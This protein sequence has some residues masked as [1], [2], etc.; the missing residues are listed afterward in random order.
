[1]GFTWDDQAD[2]SISTVG[3]MKIRVINRPRRAGDPTP[4]LAS[5]GLPGWGGQRFASLGECKTAAESALGAWVARNTTA[6][7]A[8]AVSYTV[9]GAPS[10][11]VAVLGNLEATI[12]WDPPSNLGGYAASDIT[13]LIESVG[14]AASLQYI[15][16]GPLQA[17]VTGLQNGLSYA[18]VVYAINPVGRSL[19]SAPS[20]YVTPSSVPAAAPGA[21]SIP[22]P[23]GGRNNPI[24][25][26]DGQAVVSWTLA[27]LGSPA[28]ITGFEIAAT[29]AAPSGTHTWANN[30][31]YEVFTDLTPGTPYTFKVRAQ[32]ATGWG[33][34][35]ASSASVTPSGTPVTGP[36]ESDEFDGGTL[37]ARWTEVDPL[38]DGTVTVSGGVLNLA[39]PTGGSKNHDNWPDTTPVNRTL[40]IVQNCGT[41]DWIAETKILNADANDA[42]FGGFLLQADA[43]N[44]VRFDWDG[45][46]GTSIHLYVAVWDNTGAFKQ[47][48]DTA[49]S[50]N[51]AQWMR[52]TKVGTQYTV[53]TSTDGSTFT[54][55]ASFAWTPT[56]TLI[57]LN[58]GSS[59]TATAYTAQF[60][61]FRLVSGGT[62][63][64]P[65]PPTAVAATAGAGAA[66]LTWTPGATGGGALTSYRIR[67]AT[68]S[69]G[70]HTSTVAAPASGGSITGLP[71][72]TYT[73]TV[74]AVNS[75]GR[76]TE[77]TASNSVTV[78]GS[79][80]ASGDRGPTGAHS[81]PNTPAYTTTKTKT[82]SSLSQLTSSF[83]STCVAGDVVEVTNPVSGSLT[84][85]GGGSSGWGTKVLVRPA[86]GSRGMAA[87]TGGLYVTNMTNVVFAGFKQN[88]FE[89]YDS[90]G[91][92]FW[93][94][95]QDAYS[96]IGIRP[97]SNTSAVDDCGLCEVYTPDLKI[98]NGSEGGSVAKVN[99]ATQAGTSRIARLQIIGC[100]FG[101]GA[102]QIGSDQHCDSLH[103]YT[104]G[105]S[106]GISDLLVQDT[107]C[108]G[109]Y[110]A[111]LLSDVDTLTGTTTFRNVWS[112]CA[113]SGYSGSVP[114]GWQNSGSVAYEAVQ[115][116][117]QLDCFD[118]D[119]IGNFVG[120]R[121][122][123]T[124]SG[125]TVRP[126]TGVN[127]TMTGTDTSFTNATNVVVNPTYHPTAPTRPTLSA[128]W[129][130]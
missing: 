63:T 81:P 70:A 39:V 11:V 78:V 104:N 89:L 19:A 88:S 49:I 105:S 87:T 93:R 32:N 110:G 4:F 112:S 96:Y 22:T 115:E 123:G 9:P 86:I 16:L 83:L 29:P 60:E 52:L 119:F 125:V 27:D 64:V 50:S 38:G 74:S 21:P 41:G 67:E 47:K 108:F 5:S 97:N 129:G 53:S 18:F 57:G 25:E 36:F 68:P 17:T 54:Q 114:S 77:S 91:V 23:F 20:N 66:T 14:P 124:K 109:G 126:R 107:I 24:S 62:V 8:V 79:S 127:V 71:E 10:N 35:S 103:F 55:Q 98:G 117:G 2:R 95:E 30:D 7:D 116:N 82:I 61:Y 3:D 34:W 128:I 1:M 37:N 45:D 121:S 122:K 92:W 73:F 6:Y 106:V 13:Y 65:S 111:S 84:L 118:C 48:L 43:N 28:T 15:Q 56:P 51:A 33:P 59:N 80:P 31:W 102:R 90:T 58:C 42:K 40:R 72:D 69:A 130:T 75:A 44:F 85:N 26:S 113:D 99:V 46:H 101:G 94:I 76:S 120:F 12:T 100:W